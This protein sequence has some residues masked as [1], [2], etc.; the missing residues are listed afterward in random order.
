[1]IKVFIVWGNA[2]L[3]RLQWSAAELAVRVEAVVSLLSY[4]FVA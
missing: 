1:M 4:Q 2:R 3:N